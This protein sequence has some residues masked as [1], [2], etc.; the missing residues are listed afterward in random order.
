MEQS[1]ALLETNEQNKQ[2]VENA[3]QQLQR[4]DQR[5]NIAL[6]QTQRAQ[7]QL[8]QAVAARNAAQGSAAQEGGGGVAAYDAAVASAQA[9]LRAANMEFQE[10]RRAQMEASEQLSEAEHSLEESTRAL[11]EVAAQLQ[12]ASQ[13][14]GVNLEKTRQ[15]MALPHSQLASPLLQ[16]L[17]MGQ[18]K[19]DALRQRI[20]ASLGITMSANGASQGGG[21]GGYSSPYTKTSYSQP[22]TYTDPQSKQ[23]VTKM[24]NRTVYENRNLDPNL[25]V[26][27]GTRRANGSVVKRTTT[28]LEL[29]RNGN[30]PFIPHRL[31]DG[32]TVL[33]QVELHHLSGEETQHGSRYFR[34]ADVDGS[35]VEISHLTHD[36][37]NRQLHMGT[38]SFR[39]GCR[40]EKTA[41][42]AKY[43][44]F[45]RS[46][47]RN[48]AK[49]FESTQ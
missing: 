42:G 22:V 47:W 48:R 5:A 32:S 26:P 20:A 25:V 30:A 45:R 28:N 9:E 29:M 18:E 12:Q 31:A 16:Q 38:P 41:D 15:L 1:E 40:K 3:R 35:M 36:R 46:Y 23:R 14:Y 21:G 19:L 43:D 24:S 8:Q 2:Q 10:A 39:R 37:Y 27:A 34:G 13:L 7:S 6:A 4:A 17:G 11:Q 33:A 44:S 49:K